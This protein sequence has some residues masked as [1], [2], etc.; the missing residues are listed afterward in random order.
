M[1]NR[2]LCVL[3]L[4]V[5]PLSFGQQSALSPRVGTFSKP[6]AGLSC[7]D[8]GSPD[9]TANLSTTQAFGE[10]AAYRFHGFFYTP[11]TTK[12]LCKVGFKLKTGTGDVSGK[13][14]TAYVYTLSGTTLSSVISD[15]TSAG[16]SG[17]VITGTA[18]TVIFTF[19]GNPTLSSGTTYAI[20]VTPGSTDASNY[21]LGYYGSGSMAD[22]S[23]GLWRDNL[24]NSYNPLG[25]SD[26]SASL[27]WYD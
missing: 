3:A 19:S 22:A 23:F 24:Q 18:A 25:T 17:S 16:V 8:D 21:C 4:L 20:V 5:V 26:C 1:V 10:I 15:G 27:Y 2:A 6:V 7:P 11:S 12:Q 9:I 14:Y 13:T